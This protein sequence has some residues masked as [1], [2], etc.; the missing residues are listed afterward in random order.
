MPLPIGAIRI[1]AGAATAKYGLAIRT[2]Q[3]HAISGIVPT[4]V[5]AG[6]K[7]FE[8]AGPSPDL[9]ST[10]TDL[11]S[12]FS[13]IYSQLLSVRD[14]WFFLPCGC[15]RDSPYSCLN[16]RCR[17]LGRLCLTNSSSPAHI[18][19]TGLCIFRMS[20]LRKIKIGYLVSLMEK[21]NLVTVVS[22]LTLQRAAKQVVIV[23]SAIM[24]IIA[25]SV[26]AWTAGCHCNLK[27]VVKSIIFKT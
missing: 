15:A 13:R 23:V 5:I 20:N 21:N 3:P 17:P 24:R 9:A 19:H 18:F 25:V 26:L 4:A 14:W 7:P 22:M 2:A 27:D 10:A 6:V 16:H 11:F 8:L 12:N 1:P